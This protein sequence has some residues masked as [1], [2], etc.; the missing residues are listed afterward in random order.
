MTVKEPLPKARIV[1]RFYITDDLI[2]IRLEPEVAIP[3]KPG[4]YCTIGLN[5][6]ERPYS[7]A[8][9]PREPYI[10]LF[11]EKMPTGTLTPL[12]W[13]LDVDDEVTIRPRAK[14][15]FTFEEEH[16]NQVMIATVT[17]IAPF[18][19]MI[20]NYFATASRTTHLH[21]FYLFHGASYQDEFGYDEELEIWGE[22]RSNLIYIPTVSRP[23]EARNYDWQGRTGRVNVIQDQLFKEFGIAPSDTIVYLCGHPGMISD[24]AQKLTPRGFKVKEEKYWK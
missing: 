18:M 19:S 12:L 14:G 21:T 7:I 9:G 13:K 5:G 1:E 15:R 3:F 16:F 4:Q 20:R 2:M 8:S 17:G 6:I 23:H 11:I 22:M 24:L 10:E